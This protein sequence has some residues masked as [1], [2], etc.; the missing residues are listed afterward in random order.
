MCPYVMSMC[1]V[2]LR[3]G[4][5]RVESTI[6]YVRRGLSMMWSSIEASEPKHG[7]SKVLLCGGELLLLFLLNVPAG[8]GIIQSKFVCEYFCCKIMFKLLCACAR[9]IVCQISHRLVE[10]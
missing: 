3:F 5:V 7:V 9:I 8:C 6:L 2:C 10:N 4:G 1:A